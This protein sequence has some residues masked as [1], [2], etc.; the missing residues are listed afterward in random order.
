MG[1]LESTVTDY[2]SL[3]KVLSPLLQTPVTGCLHLVVF[4]SGVTDTISAS[5]G[6]L[7]KCKFD[8]IEILGEAQHSEF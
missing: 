1:H 3:S 6:S 8:S 4:F 7:K 2:K 5:L